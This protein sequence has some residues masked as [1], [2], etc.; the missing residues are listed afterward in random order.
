[1]TKISS[2][3]RVLALVAGCAVGLVAAAPAAA[4]SGGGAGGDDASGKDERKDGRWGR[5]Q[6]NDEGWAHKHTMDA[7]TAK[8]YSEAVDLFQAEDV[9]GCL[10][11]LGKLR[12]RSL[13]PYEKA[14]VFRFRGFVEYARGDLAGARAEL[15]KAR[16]ENG[17]PAED[18]AELTYKI[19]QMWLQEQNWDEGIAGLEAYLKLVETPNAM[20][21]HLLAIAYFQ[22][23]DY[24]GALGPAQ[25]A[26][27]ISE[28]ASEGVLQ[29][30]LAIRL[31]LRQYAESAPIL[32]ELVAHYPQKKYFMQLSTVHGA[33]EKYTEALVP[34]QLAYVQDLLDQD[35]DLR[36][37]GQL[38]LFLELPYRAALVMQRGIEDEIVERDEG[39]FE[40]L[41]NSWIAAREFDRAVGP[42]ESGAALSE[43]GDLYIRLA[44]VHLQREKWSEAAAALR[45]ALAKGGLRDP[46]DAKLLMGIA[47]YSQKRPEQA[48]SWFSRA[49][50]HASTREEADVWLRY[51]D[52]ELESG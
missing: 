34:L 29:L 44:Q 2:M 7:Y 11:A 25:T 26:Y 49:R 36:R 17:L 40:L 27:E 32:E 12:M 45:S 43:N 35:S 18:Q 6:D 47:F 31:T 51:I 39:A 3:V 13:N 9:D 1:M 48:R 20:P 16:A 37:L 4:Q 28:E 50:G 22:K 10:G 46:G 8:R 38:L 14:V 19:A 42:L 33:L 5:K 23:A 30:L 52:R 41:S 24:E 21:Y 15:E